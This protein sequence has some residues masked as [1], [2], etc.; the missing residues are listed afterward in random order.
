LLRGLT[1]A[2]GNRILKAL[3]LRRNAIELAAPELEAVTLQLAAAGHPVLVELNLGGN[4]GALAPAAAA[5]LE[6]LLGGGGAVALDRHRLPSIGA[7]YIQ[8]RAG[9]GV[10]R[11]G[12]AALVQALLAANTVLWDAAGLAAEAAAA[13]GQAL[14]LRGRRLGDEGA[15]ALAAALAAGARPASVDL[16]RNGITAAAGPVLAAAVGSA[17]GLLRLS[18]AENPIAGTDAGRALAGAAAVNLLKSAGRGEWFRSS[19]TILA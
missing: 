1:A 3:N 5:G 15:A 2:S 19:Q 7:P 10:R 18:L 11:D 8:S 4:S 12:R 17:P 6:A 16:R 9:C 14:D 13:A